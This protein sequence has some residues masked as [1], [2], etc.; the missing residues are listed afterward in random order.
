ML[1]AWPAIPGLDYVNTVV[2]VGEEV[3]S[4]DG[5]AQQYAW[6]I[7]F[8]CVNNNGTAEFVGINFFSR[9]NHGAVAQQHYDSMYNKAVELGIEEYWMNTVQGLKQLNHT[10]C[11]Y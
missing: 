2:A 4:H 3:L 9:Y 5:S 6:T 7:E 8:Q 11:Y 1:G 10:N